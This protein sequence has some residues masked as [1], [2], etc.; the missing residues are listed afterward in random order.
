MD[1]ETALK[2]LKTGQNVFLTGSAGTG[3]T[4]V[5]NKY[6]SYLKDREVFPAVTAPTGVAASHLDGQTLHSFFGLGIKENINDYDLDNILQTKYLHN[7]LSKLKILIIDEISMVSPEIFEALDK[8]LRA[9]KFSPEPFGGVQVVLSGDF[10][11][12]P[13][14]SKTRKKIKFVWQTE[15]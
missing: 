6:I 14:V 8:I 9:F 13:P 5:L 1:Q 12:L 7:R 15:L 2:I 4:F 3:K 10:F 11:Q